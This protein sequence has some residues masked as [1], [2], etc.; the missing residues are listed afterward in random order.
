MATL[1]A[2]WT[3]LRAP[4]DREL[5][6]YAYTVLVRRCA[7][8]CFARRVGYELEY[9]DFVQF[10]MV[11]LLECIDRFDPNNGARF[12]T[13]A[14]YRIEGAI[15]SGIPSLSELQ[16]QVAARRRVL[17]ERNQSLLS[18][19]EPCVSA[20]ERLAQVSIGLALGFALEDSG[21]YQ[22][23]ESTTPDNA[24]SR[25]EMIQLK[26]RLAE[27]M[28]RLPEQQRTV[29]HRHYFQQV[30]F[31]DIAISLALTKGRI[32]QIHHAALRSLR[33]LQRKRGGDLGTS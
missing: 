18:A 21:L 3:D 16:Q 7:A 1:W 22:D 8:R 32:S 13:Y 26:R 24:Y 5:L 20:L 11:G 27:L 17:H 23:A 30:K 33:E 28:Q 10:G 12:E 29:I 6:V 19:A 14:S 31:E 25:V 4:A 15:L 2:R 9:A